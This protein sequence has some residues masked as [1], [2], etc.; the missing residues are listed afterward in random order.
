MNEKFT[1][2]E[3]QPTGIVRELL[4]CLTEEIHEVGQR[5]C[6]ANRFGLAEVQPGQDLTN[7]E[8]IVYELA[9]LVAVVEMLQG[10]G[11]LRYSFSDFA[12][13]KIL[14]HAKLQKY[15]QNMEQDK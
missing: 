12:K 7:E 6:K 13:M 2:P 9:D 3:E 11:V 15:L 10:C 1:S 8:R 5:I 14:K 4:D